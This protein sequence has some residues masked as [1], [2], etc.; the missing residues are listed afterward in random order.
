MYD[1]VRLTYMN[2]FGATAWYQHLQACEKVGGNA[3]DHLK[4]AI[5]KL[6]E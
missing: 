6:G 3:I 4:I 2:K 1:H 5:T